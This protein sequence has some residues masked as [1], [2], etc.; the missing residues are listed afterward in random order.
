VQQAFWE[1]AAGIGVVALLALVRFSWRQGRNTARMVEDWRGN[2]GR[3]GVAR[4]PGV[5]ERLASG[6]DHFQLL[7][8]RMDEVTS[9]LDSVQQTLDREIPKNGKPLADK[10]DAL[11]RHFIDPD[12]QHRE[13]HHQ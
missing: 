12:Y 10:I 13:E 3:P 8:L 2:E 4:R 11:Y 6:D 7:D 5:M 1:V 9:R